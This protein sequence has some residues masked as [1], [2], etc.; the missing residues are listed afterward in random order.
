MLY[1][2][3]A[4]SLTF[5]SVP[6][7]AQSS[8]ENVTI[9]ATHVRGGVYMLEGRGGN[10]GVSIGADGIMLIDDQF[11]PLAEKIEQALAEIGGGELRFVLNTHWHRDH[12]G[13]NEVFGE[14]AT[15]IAH[16]NVR[17]R[18]TTD[19][20]SFGE[21]IPAKPKQAWPVITLKQSLSVHFNGEEIEAIH[22]PHG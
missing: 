20:T 11:A 21:L 10:I 14:S 22:Y 12:T 2:I 18:L 13:G 7:T 6:V 9:K 15:I 17:K 3:L 5:C 19:Q 8:F 1:L 16:E 4:L